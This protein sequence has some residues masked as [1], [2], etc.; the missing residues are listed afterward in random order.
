MTTGYRRD[1]GTTAGDPGGTPHRYQLSPAHRDG[2][3]PAPAVQQ[4][5]GPS[6]ARLV[7]RR[8]H[9]HRKAAR[10]W[11]VLATVAAAGATMHAAAPA[12]RWWWVPAVAGAAAAVWAYRSRRQGPRRHRRYAA[13][14][15]LAAGTWLS[16]AAVAG[17]I[18]GPA[19]VTTAV[20]GL[21][22]LAWLWW[23]YHRIRPAPEVVLPAADPVLVT[24]AERVSASGGIFPGARLTA[25]GS[26]PGARCYLISGVQGEHTTEQLT[27]SAALAKIASALGTDPE[28]LHLERP[29]KGPDRN[30]HSAKMILTDESNLQLADSIDWDGPT[31]D[32]SAGT[33]TPGLY[34]DTPAWCA[35]YQTAAGQ[36][37]RAVNVAIA[38]LM[39]F[40]K[41]RLIELAVTEM[42][43]SG[44]FVVWYGD[45]Q[46]G[47]SGPGL[48]DHVGWYATRR[49]EIVRM[50]KAAYKIAKA[51]QRYD[52][53]VTWTDT[54]GYAR[55]GRGFWPA[56]AAEPFVQIVL[57]EV[58]ELLTDIRVARLVRALQRLGPKVGIGI[59]LSTQEWLMHETGGASGDPAAQSIRAFAQTGHV[60]LFKAGSDINA[61][62]L[63]GR[64]AGINPRT[65]PDEPGWCYLLGRG[66]RQVPVRLRRIGPDDLYHWLAQAGN[67]K[68]RLDD[69]SARA[70]GEDYETRWQRL[71]A[72]PSGDD[73]EAIAD[74]DNEVAELLGESLP[75]APIPHTGDLTIKQAVL[76]VVRDTGPLKRADIPAGLAQLGKQGT[77]S[78]I[79]QALASFARSG[80]LISRGGGIWDVPDREDRAETDAENRASVL[81]LAAARDT[82]PS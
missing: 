54:H 77:K 50:L 19:L 41:S 11:Y 61:N 23:Q 24:W 57:D 10:P 65:L 67:V 37:H 56:S 80:H 52:Q 40:G 26:R 53:T 3:I 15:T 27:S 45:G 16:V 70:A 44:I 7:A 63:G 38:G 64:L 35:L 46:E 20:P 76:R 59:T 36:P 30:G 69:L 48:R 8:T 43:W 4:R 75:G 29:P 32:H 47:A 81:E 14:C 33:W 31:L 9:R 2:T 79:D 1:T 74:L 22:P 60:A 51:R 17:V 72:L 5:P 68:A 12:R 42:L 39:G 13:A 78:A 49:D 18:S 82:E 58:Q 25:A 66:T 71:D 6:A 73:A 55:T 34:P 28:H 21:W 62:A